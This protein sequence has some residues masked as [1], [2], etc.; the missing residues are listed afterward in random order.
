[1]WIAVECSNRGL[2][3]WAIADE[4][5]QP[6]MADAREP[7]AEALRHMITPHLRDGSV[8]TVI[9]CGGEG[10][11]FTLVPAQPVG[12]PPAAVSY[13]DPRAA[14]FTVP[15]LSQNDPPDITEGEETAIA[16]FL[17]LN[18]DWDG[19][20]CLPGLHSRWAHVSAGEVI[21]FRSFLTGELYTALAVHHPDHDAANME[22][23]KA[24]V[25]DAMSRPE[26]VASALFS[27]RAQ[28]VLG[29]PAAKTGHVRLAGLLIGMELA[30]ARPYWLGQNVALIA[31]ATE[32]LTPLYVEALQAQ[33]ISATIFD[34]TDMVLA[35]LRLAYAKLKLS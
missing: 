4:S 32:E 13:T 17:A 12:G 6:L 2:R 10:G 1:M 26:R 27:L 19:V 5:T 23:F 16:G 20:V 15:G 8:T 31:P 25:S 34:R 29:H 22:E 21:S 9:C 28:V 33:G 18:P 24:A 30:A 11:P 14:V 3:G 7:E 35:G